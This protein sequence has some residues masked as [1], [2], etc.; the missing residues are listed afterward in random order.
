MARPLRYIRASALLLLVAIPGTVAAQGPAAQGGG[1]AQPTPL[2]LSGRT[3][4][5]G[6]T[7]TQT[8]A[9]GPTT[10]INTLNAAVGVQGLFTG[11]VPSQARQPFGGTL[12]LREA[13]Q[14]G[15]SFNLS[16]VN[17]SSVLAQ[18]QGQQTVAR[19]ALLPNINGDLTATRQQVNLGSFGIR[20]ESPLPGFNFPTVVGPFNNVDL[21]ARLSQTVMDLTA[22]NNYRAAGATLR[23]DKLM[24][25]DTQDL[26]VL[27]VGGAYLQTVTA[28][29]RVA[30]ARAQLET[31]NAL[32]RQ[33]SERRA[34]GLVAQVDVA[35]SQV[36]ALTQ[37]QRLISLQNDFAKQKINLARMI[38]LPPTDQYTLGDHIPFVAAPAISIEDALGQARDRRGDLKAAAAHVDAAERALAAAHAQ[39]LPVAQVTA[40]VGAIGPSPA[41]ARR[42]FSV[43]GTVRMPLWAGG[44]AAGQIQQAE[45][46][47]A[48]RRAEMDDMTTQLEADVRKAYLDLGALTAQVEVADQSRQVA[49]QA[50]DLTRQRFAAGVSDSVEVIQSQEALA[51]AELDYIN[52]VYAHNVAKLNLARNI[53]QASERLADFLR[54]P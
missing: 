4:P 9:P 29:A 15:L 16:S 36:Q 40:D 25:E 11:S 44:R 5:G 42:T 19:A 34:V 8:A 2:P 46:V 21:R 24:T 6:V 49:Q 47:L 17:M 52:S 30:S 12:S 43:V 26:I 14:R 53:G 22:L 39:R 20:F 31:A 33:N 38:G 7:V 3:Q 32:F 54:L 51:N 35:R 10:G 13:V 48:E 1:A 18:A 28:E 27:A 37:Q 50:L 41:D 45:A 23:A